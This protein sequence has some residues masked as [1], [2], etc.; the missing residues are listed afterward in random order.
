MM[1]SSNK[2]FSQKFSDFPK[3]YLAVFDSLIL[4]SSSSGIILESLLNR[5]TSLF[6]INGN[7]LLFEQMLIQFSIYAMLIWRISEEKTCWNV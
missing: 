1:S 7:F 5:Y 6:I 3:L 2:D 4:T